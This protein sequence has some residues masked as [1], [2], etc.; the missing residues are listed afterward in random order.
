MQPAIDCL[1]CA[2]LL[3]SRDRHPVNNF[4]LR[5]ACDNTFAYSAGLR[6][7][8]IG[9]ALRHGR[10]RCSACAAQPASL[11]PGVCRTGAAAAAP[12][13]R[14]LGQQHRP[15][16]EQATEG[17]AGPS[18]AAAHAG[19]AQCAAASNPR[20][21]GG[22]GQCHGESYLWFMPLLFFQFNS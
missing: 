9:P 3:F 5:A 16:A 7:R 15:A 4:F 14:G 12:Q 8:C 10:T 11:A 20:H 2:G 18:A 6:T 22:A 13:T 21:H 17:C 1:H 19:N